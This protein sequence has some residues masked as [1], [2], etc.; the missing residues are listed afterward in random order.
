MQNLM[1][2]V[3]A[4]NVARLGQAW[5]DAIISRLPHS[6]VVTWPDALDGPADYA[7]GWLPPE[8]LFHR[9]RRLK[10]YFVAGAG[11]EQLLAMPGVDPRLPIIRLEDAGMGRQMARYCL[12]QVLRWYTKSNAYESQQQHRIWKPL[13]VANAA[14]WPIGIF[15]L[16]RLGQPVAQAFLSLG[17]PVHGYTRSPRTIEGVRSYAD[18]EGTEEALAAFLGASRVLILMAPLT[19]DTRD[20]F[21]AMRLR[22]LPAGSYVI[23][24]ARGELLVEKDLIELLDVGH[25]C[26]ASLDVFREEPLP[27]SHPLW[28][29]PN[30]RVTP[31]IAAVTPIPEAAD[32][33]V[34][35][36]RDVESGR[37]VSG[38]VDRRRGY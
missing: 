27:A 25:L 10:A 18:A 29:H 24:V 21:N 38:V 28:Q 2:I 31:H 7:I 22:Y 32:Q 37:P 16:G 3:I 4:H 35:K 13:P 30:V 34:A 8:A 15:G 20:R 11:V 9:E 36:I 12:H 33:I 5:R 14:E 23:N 17:F 1:R 19:I 26:G 6:I